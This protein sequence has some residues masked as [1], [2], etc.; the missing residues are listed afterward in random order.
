[1]LEVTF[2]RIQERLRQLVVLG[3]RVGDLLD[4]PTVQ[5][6]QR[7]FRVGEQD[8]RVAGDQDCAWPVA[9]RSRITFK[10]AELPLWRERRLGLVEER[11]CRGRSG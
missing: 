1:M 6:E 3:V 4:G 8:W 11:R 9:S 10:K 7:S 5:A 2:G